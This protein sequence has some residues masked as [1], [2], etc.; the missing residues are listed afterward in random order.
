MPYYI[1]FSAFNISQAYN[2]IIQFILT[3]NYDINRCLT[4]CSNNGHFIP[5]SMRRKKK[6]KWEQQ[7]KKEAYKTPLQISVEFA[8]YVQMSDISL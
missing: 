6:K 4:N 2:D 7:E 1:D 5:E 8:A 3:S